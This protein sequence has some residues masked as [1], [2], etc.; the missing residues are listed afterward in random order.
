MA[1]RAARPSLGTGPPWPVL[2]RAVPSPA[3]YPTG[4]CRASPRAPLTAQARARGPVSCR[5]GPRKPGT[6]TQ[7]GPPEA[8]KLKKKHCRW[9]R[10]AGAQKERCLHR[11]RAVR[12]PHSRIELVD[13]VAPPATLTSRRRHARRGAEPRRA[14][15]PQEGGAVPLSTPPPSLAVTPAGPAGRRHHGGARHGGA[16]HERICRGARLLG[17][18]EW[19]RSGRAAW[20][21]GGGAARRHREEGSPERR[22]GAGVRRGRSSRQ[23]V[24]AAEGWGRRG[25]GEREVGVGEGERLAGGGARG[26]WGVAGWG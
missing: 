3:Q 7:I 4:P 13:A 9:L 8:Q 1:I 21:R 11:A 2:Y 16:R 23:P 17:R 6:T 5:A 25:E 12:R 10:W 14:W 24:T 15:W 19:E 22:G 20:R 26:R 18:V